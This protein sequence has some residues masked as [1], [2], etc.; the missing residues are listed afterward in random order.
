MGSGNVEHG[1]LAR[2]SFQVMRPLGITAAF[3]NDKH[4]ADA[5]FTVLF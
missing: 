4:F 3:T 1:T 2:I 5:G